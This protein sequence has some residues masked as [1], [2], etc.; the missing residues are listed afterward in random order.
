MNE[1]RISLAAARVNARMT[2]QQVAEK[3]G[4]SKQTII[5]WEKGK[6]VPGIPEICMMSKLYN[7]PSIFFCLRTLQIVEFNKKGDSNEK[8]PRSINH[9]PI[10]T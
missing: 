3:M 5:N 1:I 6:V 7:M 4:V 9:N 2:Q 10:T 8:K